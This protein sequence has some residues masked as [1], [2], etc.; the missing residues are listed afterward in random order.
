MNKEHLAKLAGCLEEMGY[1]IQSLECHCGPT[2]ITL[3]E[4]KVFPFAET[5]LQIEALGQPDT[6]RPFPQFP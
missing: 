4:I 1:A 3:K 2:S 6:R 5:R